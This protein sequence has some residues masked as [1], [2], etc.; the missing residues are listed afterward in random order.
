MLLFSSKCDNIITQIVFERNLVMEENKS[1]VIQEETVTENVTEVPLAETPVRKNTKKK[2]FKKNK[3]QKLWVKILKW[4]GISLV[5]LLLVVVLAFLTIFYSPWFPTQRDQYILMTYG[6]SNPW[7][8]TLF[9]TQEQIDAAFDRNSVIPPEGNTN[10]ELV[11]PN[12]TP[13]GEVIPKTFVT[14][15]K[16]QGEVIYQDEGVQIITFSGKTEAGKYTARLIQVLDPSRVF[17][18]LT[19]QLVEPDDPNADGFSGDGQLIGD[20]LI[21]NDALCG[22]NAGGW[23]DPKGIGSGGMPKDIVIKDGVIKQYDDL[24]RHNIIGFNED[25]VLVLG[26]FSNEEIIANGIRD[27]MSW[28]PF[29][30]VNGEKAETKGIA[31]GYDPRSAI[32]QRA[33]GTVLLL[34]VD[35]STLRGI[36]GA[37]MELLMDIMW[38]FGAVNASN[39]D[40]GTSASM[41]L[42]GKIIN[43]VCN[44]AI[45]HRGRYLNSCW[46]VKNLPAEAE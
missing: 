6:T 33:D 3:K 14:S 36:D 31:G 18:G 19:N 29:L 44:P 20:M 45:V 4:F 25:N 13:S 1:T 21:M 2:K 30:I 10:P 43:T 8:C 26:N 16:Y 35:G 22:I 41:G 38:E 46:L 28:E 34:V 23:N 7:L 12:G 27:G 11:D 37:N 40:G 5:A 42:N 15:E 9:F 17:L 39:L 24:E 32:G